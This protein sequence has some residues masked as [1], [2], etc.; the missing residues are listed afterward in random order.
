MRITLAIV[1]LFVVSS[2]E[3][4]IKYAPLGSFISSFPMTIFAIFLPHRSVVSSAL[5][6]KYD[7]Y[8]FSNVVYTL[9]V[10]N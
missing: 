5:S 6:Q 8:G 4:A 2:S 7:S 10:V 1:E 3:E 9:K